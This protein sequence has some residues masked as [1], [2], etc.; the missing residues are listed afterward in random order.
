[1]AK[2]TA[3]PPFTLAAMPRAPANLTRVTPCRGGFRRATDDDVG[4]VTSASAQLT[5]DLKGLS[6]DEI[7]AGSDRYPRNA[8]T[9][10][11]H[12]FSHLTSW[13]LALGV[14]NSRQLRRLANA[15]G[16]RPCSKRGTSRM[17]SSAA[18]RLRFCLFLSAAVSYEARFPVRLSPL[19]ERTTS[20]MKPT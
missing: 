19:L 7:K 16:T 4:G 18:D 17:S 6:V 2:P 12:V 14:R 8:C 10:D 20:D 15:A 1:L 5:R 13:L 11:P 3:W 9:S